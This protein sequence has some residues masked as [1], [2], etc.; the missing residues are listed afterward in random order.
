MWYLTTLPGFKGRRVLSPTTL[1]GFFS[2]FPYWIDNNYFSEIDLALIISFFCHW[3]TKKSLEVTKVKNII[4]CVC[5]WS[6]FIHDI[7]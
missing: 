1:F 5:V 2:A 4:N 3:D 7:V 6:L